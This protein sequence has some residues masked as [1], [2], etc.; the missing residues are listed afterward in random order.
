MQDNEGPPLLGFAVLLENVNLRDAR[1][2]SI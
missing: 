1:L 2:A